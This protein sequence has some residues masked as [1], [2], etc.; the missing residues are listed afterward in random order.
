VVSGTVT[1][2]PAPPPV[3]GFASS[4]PDDVGQV[5][6][7]N[8]TTTGLGPI[9]Y[10]W[11]FGDGAFSTLENPTHTYSLPSLYTVILTATNDGGPNSVTGT[12]SIEGPPVPSFVTNGPV[13]VGTPVVFTNTTI[14]N[15][16][17]TTWAWNLGDGTLSTAQTPPPHIYAV[18]TYTVT[19]TAV[20][21]KG[22]ATYTQTAAVSPHYIYLP[23]V[24]R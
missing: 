17:V 7:F 2:L 23:I 8:N 20:N 4:S 5:T 15:P 13:I 16:A 12:V 1:I 14:A 24:L 19:L 18:G 3:A 11:A 22:M 6:T 21:A 9:T 10:E